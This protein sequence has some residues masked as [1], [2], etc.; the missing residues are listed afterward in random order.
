MDSVWTKTVRMPEF[1]DLNGDIKTD[2][3]IIGG[4]PPEFFAPICCSR[5][6]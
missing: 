2:V 6:E 5:P 4:A 1:P 3:L